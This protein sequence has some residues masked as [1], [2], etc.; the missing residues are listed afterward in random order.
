M[1]QG[2]GRSNKLCCQ[3]TQQAL[4]DPVLPL[5]HLP[6]APGCSDPLSLPLPSIASAK[7]FLCL[8]ADHTTDQGSQMPPLFLSFLNSAAAANKR[9]QEIKELS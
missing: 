6:P 3:C 8:L 2:L 1:R 5:S 7:V 4:V 9:N